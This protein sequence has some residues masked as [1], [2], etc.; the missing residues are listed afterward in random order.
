MQQRERIGRRVCVI[1]WSVEERGLSEAMVVT[2]RRV[3]SIAGPRVI[4]A[5]AGGRGWHCAHS[6]THSQ[7]R[8]EVGGGAGAGVRA[9]AARYEG[10]ADS[11]TQ[12]R[13]VAAGLAQAHGPSASRSFSRPSW[14]RAWGRLKGSPKATKV[15]AR[16]RTG[17][18]AAFSRIS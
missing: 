15:W 2:T 7:H 5:A 1:D 8:E 11:P 17:S 6:T 3:P 9:A 16:L 18:R 13:K 4:G 12:P 10:G 14:R